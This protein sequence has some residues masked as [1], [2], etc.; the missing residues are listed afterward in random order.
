M[1][2]TSARLL[3]AFTYPR[4]L[5]DFLE[6][7]APLHATHEIRA[8]VVDVRHETHDVATLFLAPSRWRGH[9]PGQ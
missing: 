9:R 8:R 4:S 6:L 1:F 7:V 2:E 5:H 3:G